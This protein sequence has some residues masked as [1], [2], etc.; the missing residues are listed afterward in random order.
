[1]AQL[2][3]LQS[4]VLVALAGLQPPWTLSGG[5]AL[6]G[7]HLHHRTTRDLDLFWHGRDTIADVRR[8]VAARL[9]AAGF[10]VSELRTFDTFTTLRVTQGK[11]TVVVDLVAEPVPS[12]E[13]A[14][15]VEFRGARI[16]IDT[17]HEVLV[18]KLCTL[19]HRAE[20]RDLVDI[21]ALLANGGDLDRALADAPTKDGGFSALTLGWTLGSWN[22]AEVARQTGAADRAEQLERFR[23]YLLSRAAGERP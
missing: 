7:F 16:L 19:L 2:S 10:D 14:Q 6:V 23:Q 9:R 12:V 22:V 17:P 11:E 1:L 8:E 4:R 3:E 13:P 15:S 18:N 21:E 20:L 5:G